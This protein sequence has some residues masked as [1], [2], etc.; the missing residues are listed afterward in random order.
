MRKI[1]RAGNVSIP[2]KNLNI[3]CHK[4]L[5]VEFLT[6]KDVGL[7]HHSYGNLVDS[8][9]LDRQPVARVFFSMCSGVF[10]CVL[11]D[12]NAA[13][14]N[15]HSEIALTLKTQ[16][17]WHAIWI[18]NKRGNRQRPEVDKF[19]GFLVLSKPIFWPILVA[20]PIHMC[21]SHG[22]QAKPH[23]HLFCFCFTTFSGSQSL[24]MS[25]TI[26][27][28]LVCVVWLSDGVFTERNTS[29]TSPTSPKPAARDHLLSAM[30]LCH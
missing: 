11:R 23:V 17:I 15:S 12:S 18:W 26:A 2:K 4:T 30:A 27:L 13:L 9:I 29:P 22:S 21:S 25:Q 16:N 5:D 3:S 1:C 8:W 14:A 19:D 10:W 7:L 28:T 6:P 20:S 24:K